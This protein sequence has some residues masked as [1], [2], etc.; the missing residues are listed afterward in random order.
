MGTIIEDGVNNRKQGENGNNINNDRSNAGEWYTS[1]PPS[2]GNRRL[3][4]CGDLSGKSRATLRLVVEGVR[5]R[6]GESIVID[7]WQAQ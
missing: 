2:A 7:N 3:E 4:E 1:T 6:E 5:G